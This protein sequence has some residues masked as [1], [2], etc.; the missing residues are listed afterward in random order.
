MTPHGEHQTAKKDAQDVEAA[1][2][3]AEAVECGRTKSGLSLDGQQWKVIEVILSAA[4]SAL[5]AKYAK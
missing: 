1:G 2:I 5:L 3:A 4:L